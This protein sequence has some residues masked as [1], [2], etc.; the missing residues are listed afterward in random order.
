MFN[1][2]FMLLRCLLGLAGSGKK[3]QQDQ[4]QE[5]FHK[6]RPFKGNKNGWCILRAWSEAQYA[7]LSM[8]KGSRA[9]RTSNPA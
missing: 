7:F 2:G 6:Y 8:V 5:V 4:D 9:M 1:L 3:Y